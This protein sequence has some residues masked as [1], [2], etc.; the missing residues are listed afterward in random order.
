MDTPLTEIKGL[1][2]I[3]DNFGA[4][5]WFIDPNILSKRKACKQSITEC[6]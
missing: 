5:Y 4:D 1:K 6:A 2:K 3:K